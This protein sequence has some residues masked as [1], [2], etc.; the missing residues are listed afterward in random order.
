MIWAWAQQRHP[1]VEWFGMVLG[2]GTLSAPVPLRV[3]LLA[4]VVL[5]VNTAAWLEDLDVD[6]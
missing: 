2:L 6:A 3:Q 5:I 1:R 4:G